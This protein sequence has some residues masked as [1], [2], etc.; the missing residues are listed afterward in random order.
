MQGYGSNGRP[1]ALPLWSA[2]SIIYYLP[3]L[4]VTLHQVG[5]SNTGTSDGSCDKGM[6]NSHLYYTRS[7]FALFVWHSWHSFLLI[8]CHCGCM[9]CRVNWLYT[10]VARVVADVHKTRIFHFFAYFPKTL[11]W[12]GII[13]VIFGLCVLH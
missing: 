3:C 13:V 4:P 7:S 1:G 11:P 5:Y 6:G 10:L 9:T 8:F 2:C 12:S